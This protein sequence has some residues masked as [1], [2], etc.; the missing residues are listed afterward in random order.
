MKGGGGGV[1]PFFWE[2][3]KGGGK[4]PPGVSISA[5]LPRNEIKDW[6]ALSTKHSNTVCSWTI[7]CMRGNNQTNMVIL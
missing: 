1:F 3:G 5:C 2:K 4:P 6:L 7:S